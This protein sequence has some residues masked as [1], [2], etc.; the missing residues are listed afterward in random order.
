MIR[1]AVLPDDFPGIPA[2]L[3]AQPGDVGRG[4]PIPSV[5]GHPDTAGIAE[6]DVADGPE[7]P[8][9]CEAGFVTGGQ[10]PYGTQCDLAPGNTGPHR[11][12]DPFG[13][14]DHVEWSG[15]GTAAGDPLPYRDVRWTR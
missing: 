1:P 7:W 5:T 13:G 3:D 11:R 14:D 10:D 4:L 2:S 9:T 6:P 12:A 15:G 8:E